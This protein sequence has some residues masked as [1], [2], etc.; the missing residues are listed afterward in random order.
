MRS[1][2][3][4]ILIILVFNI[5]GAL[6]TMKLAPKVGLQTWW[7]CS[8]WSYIILMALLIMI[9]KGPDDVVYAYILF[10]P[11]GMTMASLVVA[12]RA[13]F[14]RLVPGGDEAEFYGF[15]TM[16]SVILGWL[17]NLLITIVMEANGGD[18]AAGMPVIMVF[19]LTGFLIFHFGIDFERAHADIAP[20]L[21]YRHNFENV[22]PNDDKATLKDAVVQTQRKASISVA[23][24]GTFKG[25]LKVTPGGKSGS[26]MG[27]SFA[28]TPGSSLNIPSVGSGSKKGEPVAYLTPL[29]L[30]VQSTPTHRIRASPSATTSMLTQC[31]RQTRPR[32]QP[33][34]QLQPRSPRVGKAREQLGP[35]LHRH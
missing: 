1:M 13:I 5:V 15:Y 3:Y 35:S 20:T 2:S 6:S 22:Q 4:A 26:F 10:I 30:V 25:N 12:Q 18:P 32:P 16:A 23:L 17:P 34:F 14:A 29:Q 24:N 33:Q 21:K 27:G 28:L 11:L 7:K 8:V 19:F 31:S 9:C